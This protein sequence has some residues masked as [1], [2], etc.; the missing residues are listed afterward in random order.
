MNY[1][2][3]LD[4]LF[5]Q[6]PMYQRQGA[7]A[8][9]IDLTNIKLLSK[10]LN[11]PEQKFK[12]IHVGGTNGK[13]STSHMLASILQEAGYRVGL[14]TSPHLVDFRERIKVDGQLISEEAVVDF[15]AQ[16]K[17][18]FE[19]NALSFFEMTVG[20]AFQFFAKQKVDIA[21]IEV[22]L[23]GRLDST[24]I[25][26]PEVSVITNISLEHTE[27]LGDSLAEIA[28][29]KGG[30]IKP[31]TPCVIGEYNEQTYPVFRSLAKLNESELLLAEQDLPKETWQTDLKGNY[32]QKNIQTVLKTIEVLNVKNWKITEADITSGLQNVVNHTGLLGRWQVCEEDPKLICDTAHNASGLQLVMQQ[33]EEENYHHLHIILGVVKEKKLDLIL[34]L[35]PL[36]ASYYFTCPSIPRRLP[37]EDLEEQANYFH[38]K[39][40]AY[41][42]VELAYAAAKRKAK[43]EDLIFIGGSTFTVADFLNFKQLK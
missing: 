24:N 31:K 4:W 20:M 43:K 11:H 33:L 28:F 39:G 36:H 19:T 32:Q 10:Y 7:S 22:G 41:K 13:G 42:N 26:T 12:S 29:E 2:Q 23:G 6:L 40:K 8:Y 34:G 35:L 9:K 3:T 27:F 21:L 30:I 18:F 15:V 37:A 38:L 14:Y 1:Q 25:I 17:S 16:N 5:H